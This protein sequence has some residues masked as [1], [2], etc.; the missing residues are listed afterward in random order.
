M[1]E[2][3][4]VNKPENVDR[5]K[6]FKKEYEAGGRKYF[7]GLNENHFY[8]VKK[9]GTKEKNG[10]VSFFQKHPNVFTVTFVNYFLTPPKESK[11]L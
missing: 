1:T 10:M 4:I 3:F 7:K 8:R 2:Y 9:N 11:H 6:N 5:I